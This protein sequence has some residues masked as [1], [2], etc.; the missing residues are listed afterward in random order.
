VKTPAAVLWDMD[1]TLVDTEPYWFDI[2]F[3]LVAEF[4]G[5]WTEA[6]AQSLV[7][8]DLL[9]SA[10]ALRTRG[11]VELDPV[12]V[13]ERMLDGVIRRVAEQLPWRP[14]APELLAECVAAKIP[15]VMVTMSWRRLAD[16]VIASAP[17]GSFVASITGDEV[18]NGKPHPEPYVAAAAAL[19]VDPADCVAIEDSPTG[20][21]S[22]LAAGCATLGVP[23][24]VPVVAAPGLTLVDSLVGLGVADLRGLC[25]R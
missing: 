3:E 1:G 14:G 21:A 24:V 16:A 4:G 12:D 25:A 6:D 22:A 15:C 5:T 10:R 13:V 23:H 11:S 17:A 2:E 9:D 18:V 8:F 20:V 19:G 7:G